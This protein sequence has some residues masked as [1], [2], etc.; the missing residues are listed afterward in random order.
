MSNSKVITRLEWKYPIKGASP[1]EVETWLRSHTNWV[2]AFPVRWV[3]SRYYDYPDWRLLAASRQG[4]PTRSKYRMRWYDD[5]NQF[6]WELKSRRGEVVSKATILALPPGLQ[7][8]VDIRYRRAYYQW[9]GRPDVRL[10]LEWDLSTSL[11]DKNT[12]RAFSGPLLE[13]K[14]PTEDQPSL[15]D[16]PWRRSRHSKYDLACQVIY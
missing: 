11:P 16:L 7:A 10:T 6:K 13:L 2:S 12:Y 3:H 1:L 4:L 5:P 14:L 8:V 9:P 15:P